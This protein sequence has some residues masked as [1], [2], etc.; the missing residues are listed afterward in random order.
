MVVIDEESL[1]KIIREVVAES[2]EEAN[3]RKI[4]KFYTSKETQEILR[5]SKTT[6]HKW[7]NEGAFKCFKRGDV[8][9]VPEE[10]IQRLILNNK[11]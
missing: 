2:V 11:G 9:L 6:F 8:V 1:T 4:A 7:K 3:K 10:E 5:I